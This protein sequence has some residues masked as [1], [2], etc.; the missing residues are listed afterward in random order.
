MRREITWWWCYKKIVRIRKF[1]NL[2]IIVVDILVPGEAFRNPKAATIIFIKRLCV[3]FRDDPLKLCLTN[4]WMSPMRGDLVSVLSQS[5][6]P[7]L[8]HLQVKDGDQVPGRDGEVALHLA[9]EV[10]QDSVAR[11]RRYRKQ[12]LRW[13]WGV[14]VDNSLRSSLSKKPW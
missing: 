5:L 13:H 1:I 8:P 2:L 11:H 4:L 14:S 10:V 6:D 3:R 12:T 7:A 9:Y